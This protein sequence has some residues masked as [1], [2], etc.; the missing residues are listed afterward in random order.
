MER[1]K[2]TK[3]QIEKERERKREVEKGMGWKGVLYMAFRIRENL[4]F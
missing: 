1:E 4:N 3:R 2:V